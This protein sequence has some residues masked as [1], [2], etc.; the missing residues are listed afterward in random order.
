MLKKYMQKRDLKK[1]QEPAAKKKASNSS[2]PIFCVQK[3]DASHLH[4]DFRLEHKGELLSWAIPKGPSMNPA[5]KRL[6]VRVE[7]HPYDY[8][9]FEGVIPEGNY[10]A[11][12]VM[13]W[14]EGIYSAK[15]VETKRE[16]EKEI[17]KGLK[18]GRLEFHLSG[19]KLK[20]GFAL[21]RMKNDD[22]HWL[23]IKMK[24]E[25]ATTK[26]VLDE[27]VV[28]LDKKRKSHL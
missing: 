14:D 15:G 10:G 4:Y 18:E 5:N 26:D 25:Y 19:H 21:I 11:G 28:V 27:E 12:T 16:T 9:D 3:H 7:E 1:T 22:K 17:T 6:A 24:D 13:L 8:H 2:Y 20:G 23:L